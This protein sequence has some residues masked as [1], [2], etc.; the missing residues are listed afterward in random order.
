MSTESL[1]TLFVSHGAPT[2]PL[3]DVPARTFLTSL[4][5]RYRNVHAVL[6][7]SAHWNTSR[8]AINAVEAPETIH[9][10][11]GFPAELYRMRYDARG[12][13]DLAGQVVD[14]IHRA[15]LSCDLDDHRGL[16]HGAWVPLMLMFPNAD[17]PVVQLS[18]QR[19]LDPAQHVALGAAISS[20]RN[21]GVLI[22]GSGGAVHP[23][24]YA[25]AS[26]GEGAAT[27]DW[28]HEF[29]GWL[30][31]AV[32]RGDRVSLV[33]YRE[34]GPFAERAHPYPDHFMPLLVA[35]GAAGDDARGSVLH[36]S[37]YWGDLAMDAYEFD[38][39]RS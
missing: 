32:T 30:T 14:L 10:F 25:G 20:L 3:E 6:C 37:W 8:P 39:D 36:H 24:G 16:D 34:R 26:L 7:V 21:D 33:K 2:L 13:P 15:G 29:G 19:H 38:S 1:P 28:A 17:V 31:D 5:S 18:I 12:S 4:G 27:D 9:D 11:Y 35:F 22:L 23:L